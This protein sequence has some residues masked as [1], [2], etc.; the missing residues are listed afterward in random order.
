MD[1]E[2]IAIKYEIDTDDLSILNNMKIGCSF[3]ETFKIFILRLYPTL[4]EESKEK[5]VDIVTNMIRSRHTTLNLKL[6]R[7]K[8]GITPAKPLKTNPSLS[9]YFLR[10]KRVIETY[11]FSR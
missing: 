6:Q 8:S 2:R 1:L 7:K 11:S 4:H 9:L 10:S 5:C 3:R